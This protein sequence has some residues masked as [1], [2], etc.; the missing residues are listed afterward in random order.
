MAGET[1]GQLLRAARMQAGFATIA[2]FANALSEHGDSGFTEDTIGHW[3]NDRRNP[4][5]SAGDRPMM[6]NIFS[7]LSE[8]GGFQTTAEIDQMLLVLDH[9]PLNAEERARYF[10]WLELAIENLPEKPFFNHLIGREEEIADIVNALSKT[11]IVVISGIGGIGKTAIAYEVARAVMEDHKFGKLAWETAKSEEFSGTQIR[12]RADQALSLSILL[13]SYARQLGLDDLVN[14]GPEQ[15]RR[16]LRK[17]FQS[18]KYL[19]I[20]DNLETLDAAENVARDL[21]QLVNA[22]QCR[23]LI[24]SRERLVNES[25]VYDHFLKG[26]S[27]PASVEL[28]QD[29]AERRGA[30]AIQQADTSL[31]ERIYEVT[32]GMPL[33]LKL[34]V[35]QSLLGIAID[36]ELDRLQGTVDEQQLY[37]F[38]YLVIWEKLTTVA[39]QLLVGAATFATSA[40]RSMLQPVSELADSPFNDA[41]SELVR[42]S[43]MEVSFHTLTTQQRYDIH[44]VTRW[45]IN[46]PLTD[47]WANQQGMS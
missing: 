2:A 5:R 26:L 27:E 43:L 32:E 47:L 41:V 10:P 3:E 4:Y 11:H 19:I 22:T 37:Q 8:R 16:G 44:A 45:F 30:T 6:L 28:L 24:T 21:Y 25:Y 38:I 40:I 1:F 14:Q 15:L 39:Q 12:V 46:G 42:M 23:V 20:L 18:G 29:E 9:A 36:E 7:F 31:L 33:A 17:A 13:A 35:S 34:I